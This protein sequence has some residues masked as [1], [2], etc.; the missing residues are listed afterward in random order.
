M[1]ID[2][3]DSDR[4]LGVKALAVYGKALDAAVASCEKVYQPTLGLQNEKAIAEGAADWLNE[5]LD[6]M[7]IGEVR[8][9]DM[10]SDYV[11]S[12]RM[13]ASV[14]LSQLGKLAEKQG[15]LLVP[16]DETNEVMSHVLSLVD[17][18][19][20]QLELNGTVHQHIDDAGTATVSVN[21]GEPMPF[22]SPAE[23]K[24]AAKKIAERIARPAS[25]KPGKPGT[26]GS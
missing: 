2:F 19:R 6:E 22:N 24:R 5:R 12:L 16:L 13:A 26:R 23:R 15:D 17:R 11:L 8:E 9:C 25:R 10:P 7:G 4:L 18:L 20:G 21:G 1:L 14:Y 3:R